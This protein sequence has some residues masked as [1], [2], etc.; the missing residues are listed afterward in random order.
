VDSYTGT[1][2]LLAAA[3]WLESLLLGSV[4]VAIAT[5]AVGGFGFLVMSGRVN[6]RTGGQI[7]LGCFVL[8]GARTI[9]AGL[10]SVA[11][12]GSA[13]AYA[14]TLPKA[15]PVQT[16]GRPGAPVNNDPFAGASVPAGT[17]SCC[18]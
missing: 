1:S 2:S 12:D 5:I 3:R 18:D 11:G 6:V 10:Q 16:A 4:A 15:T 13:P 14:Y 8:F 9:A 17:G 7:I